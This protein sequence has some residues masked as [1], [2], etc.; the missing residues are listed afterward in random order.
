MV[1]AVMMDVTGEKVRV[2][3]MDVTG[4]MMD[5]TGDD[6]MDDMMDVTGVMMVV[7]GETAIGGDM[8]I[9]GKDGDLL[10]A[11]QLGMVGIIGGLVMFQRV[12]APIMPL[13]NAQDQ[14]II[15]HVSIMLI[16]IVP[17]VW[18]MV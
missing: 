7:A 3:M 5:V 8:V 9:H 18:S 1:L 4:D 15:N 16:M 12:P 2:V 17:M 11:G 10:E 13:I 14:V 6:M